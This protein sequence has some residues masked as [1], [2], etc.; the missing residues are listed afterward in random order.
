[1]SGNLL[2]NMKYKIDGDALVGISGAKTKIFKNKEKQLT[3]GYLKKINTATEKHL[4]KVDDKTNFYDVAKH[5]NELKL[6]NSR[7]SGYKQFI[8]LLEKH[9]TDHTNSI[10]ASGPSQPKQK[11][12]RT[13]KQYDQA[14][15]DKALTYFAHLRGNFYLHS[16]KYD[17]AYVLEKLKEKNIL[18]TQSQLSPK[19]INSMDAMINKHNAKHHAEAT[20][21]WKNGK[22]EYIITA[23]CLVWNEQQQ[24]EYSE[25]TEFEIKTDKQKHEITRADVIEIA[26]F[27]YIDKDYPDF[28]R[29]A[30]PRR[31]QN[32]YVIIELDPDADVANLSFENL[33]AYEYPSPYITRPNNDNTIIGWDEYATDDNFKKCVEINLIHQCHGLVEKGLINPNM[34]C[35]EY[36]KRFMEKRG[37]V[38]TYKN[39]IEYVKHI[40]HTSIYFFDQT[41]QH[42]IDKH[43]A[44][45]EHVS[46]DLGPNIFQP[47]VE[48][49]ISAET[50]N[51]INADF[52]EIGLEL[53]AG[54]RP[55]SSND[56]TPPNVH[57]SRIVNTT[58]VAL[59]NG[60]IGT[61]HMDIVTEPNVKKSVALTGKLPPMFNVKDNIEDAYD[62]EYFEKAEELAYGDNSEYNEYKDGI[63]KNKN[64]VRIFF[65]GNSERVESM[66]VKVASKYKSL[67]PEVIHDDGA[68]SGFRH[69]V[70]KQI[71][72]LTSDYYE[73]KQTC[74]ELYK[75][76]GFEDFKFKNQSWFQVGKLVLEYMD[77][78][79]WDNLMTDLS[80]EQHELYSKH[81]SSG[82]ICRHDDDGWL[83]LQGKESGTSNIV[84]VD[85]IKQFSSLL[86]FRKEN[87]VNPE[88][89]EDWVDFDETIHIGIP[90]G[91]YILRPGSYGCDRTKVRFFR[92]FYS[93]AQVRRMINHAFVD[94]N[95]KLFSFDDI[96]KVQLI[97]HQI[98]YDYLAP[99]VDVCHNTLGPKSGKKSVNALVG[100]MMQ[101]TKKSRYTIFT[102][103]EAYAQAC[104][105][106]Y[107]KTKGLRTSLYVEQ[108]DQETGQNVYYV[109]YQQQTKNY[110]TGAPIWCQIQEDSNW[111]LHMMTYLAIYKSPRAEVLTSNVDAVTIRNGNKD[112]IYEAAINMQYKDEIDYIGKCKIEDRIKVKGHPYTY[113]TQAREAIVLPEVT[114]IIIKRDDYDETE[115]N[116]KFYDDVKQLMSTTSFLI[117]AYLA[118]SGKTWLLVSLFVDD[119]SSLFLVPTHEALVNIQNTAKAQG[120]TIN[121]LF[122]IANFLTN[123]KTHA[124]QIYSLRR[125]KHI[126][127]DEVYQ[128]NKNDIKKI[129]EVKEQF[130]TQI[131]AAG[132]FDQ[133]PAVDTNN[134]NYDLKDNHFFKDSLLDGH[135][136]KLNYMKGYGRF[137]DNLHEDLIHIV[138][139]GTI[140]DRFTNQV[141]TEA[142]YF[143]L[144]VT[145]VK[146]NEL[147][148]ACSI[149]YI[150]SPAE[151]GLMLPGQKRIINDDGWCY[152]VGM[153]LISY[154]NTKINKF[155]QNAGND[156]KDTYAMFKAFQGWK[157]II[158]DQRYEIP[159]SSRASWM[160]RIEVQGKGFRDFNKW[161]SMY[162]FTRW[163]QIT[164]AHK[165]NRKSRK[166][167]T[168]YK[169]IIK[170]K[171]RYTINNITVISKDEDGTRDIYMDLYCVSTDEMLYNIPMHII[172]TLFQPFFASTIA[173]IQGAKIEQPFSIWEME[174]KIFDRNLLNSATGRS[175]CRE[176]VHFSNTNPNRVYE[177]VKYRK[178]VIVNSKPSHNSNG[179]YETK[180]YLVMCKGQPIYRGHTILNDVIDRLNEHWDDA[181]KNATNKFHKFLINQN[182]ND[183]DIVV[184][185]IM[186]LNNQQE[187]EDHEMLLLKQDLLNG[188]KMLNTKK[189]TKR[190]TGK[191]PIV[192]TTN[193][194][195]LTLE[196]FK[197]IQEG[198][199]KQKHLI[200]QLTIPNHV[201]QSSFITDWII[202]KKKKNLDTRKRDMIKHLK[203]QRNT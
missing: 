164:N 106:F 31:G 65:E 91:W 105:N 128:T 36:I 119:G 202:R 111:A 146:R 95:G 160:E 82:Y 154:Y 4:K 170:N 190:T 93:Y 3:A 25:R 39:I 92:N 51:E 110:H 100:G 141:A 148:K 134:D 122:V 195:Q 156:F 35:H 101:L 132:A 45:R 74:D 84:T 159:H 55:G 90:P 155:K 136:I 176:N 78:A 199:T 73:R 24:S 104:R 85:G 112:F 58:I 187:A 181:R 49:V 126:F 52:S 8:D 109:T 137:T 41:C 44:K 54:S 144:T 127:I 59:V 30:K 96:L 7:I 133:N 63:Q 123:N 203:K 118:G 169:Y 62:I 197:Q 150:K 191:T 83:K 1:M 79:L 177:W 193:K 21:K 37:N 143:H 40:G 86:K 108:I 113:Y 103:D 116:T 17:R 135:E 67:I 171:Y 107:S 23:H 42:L 117:T 173:G 145:K 174:T 10:D 200:Q 198:K 139:N 20:D 48:R 114:R 76:K 80:E 129:Y 6:T 151:G 168:S 18:D 131:I 99:L 46:V 115:Y 15:Q 89:F 163:R 43:I 22:N 47:D 167:S 69:P 71:F 81:H 125:F 182:P 161:I 56:P 97:R 152:G 70:S 72:L 19:T 11:R 184:T 192:L 98:P 26:G 12:T 27:H 2:P 175:T 53:P 138:D 194:R 16:T 87:Y 13:K 75:S 29:L 149:R 166:K 140:P 158:Q 50:M 9:V 66:L 178:F 153:P 120:K 172:S 32:E 68:I 157:N 179:Y 162:M 77:I 57:Q 180:L 33:A 130:G 61:P 5:L 38:Y 28:M 121:N 183:I 60:T 102:Y 94:E 201:N 186:K 64:A 142:H 34:L 147:A 165:G 185:E 124:E 88:P 189:R 196:R 14:I 188:H